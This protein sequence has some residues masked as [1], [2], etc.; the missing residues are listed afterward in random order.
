M[1]QLTAQDYFLNRKK[2]II[3]S[4]LKQDIND[5]FFIGLDRSL[6][7]TGI[8][9]VKA[10]KYIRGAQLSS[11]FYGARRLYDLAK[12]ILYYCSAYPNC[13]VIPEG[14]SYMSKGSSGLSL[15]EFGGVMNV[16]FLMRN[17]KHLECAPQ[18]LKKYATG[19]GNCD[20]SLV[21]MNIF[22]K[23]G[24]Q[25]IGN[26]HADSIALSFLGYHAFNYLQNAKIVA[27]KAY[28]DKDIECFTTFLSL[29]KKEKK[30]KLNHKQL[31][32]DLQS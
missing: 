26:D 31:A 2:E 15:A 19:V 20:K 32:L 8:A 6:T 17:I 21:P 27:P 25:A 12:Q 9:V 16:F 4:Y 11:K 13:L 29:E 7:S 23:F 3:D 28:T 24:V 22:K 18:S 30:K 1:A 10:G 14:Y 5:V